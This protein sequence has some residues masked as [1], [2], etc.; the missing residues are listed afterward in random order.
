[1]LSFFIYTM[2]TKRAGIYKITNTITQDFYI[3]SAVNFKKRFQIHLSYLRK[4]KHHS[5]YLQNS[6]NKYG[7]SIFIFEELV[8]CPQE[9]LLK[10]EQWFLDSLNPIYNICKVAGSWLGQKHS[11]ESK[12]NMKK[13]QAL[14]ADKK[15]AAMIGRKIFKPIN[16][17]KSIPIVQL[18]LTGE[19]IKEWQSTAE[20]SRQLN[21][22]D[23]DISSVCKKRRVTSKGFKWV[24][25][26]EYYS[27]INSEG[28]WI[29]SKHYRN[30][31]RGLH[32][33]GR[34]LTEE[35]KENIG[36]GLKNSKRYS[37]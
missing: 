21:I 25:A 23:S 2:I 35:H 18:S 22:K 3:G 5:R 36:N 30:S 16:N 13:A 14:V 32:M 1:M 37:K 7:E 11:E 34:K 20:I 26:T 31:I 29:D 33:K 9:Y 6:F 8:V 19:F 27:I 10:L 24:Y 15:R 28:V 12:A 4:N 17:K